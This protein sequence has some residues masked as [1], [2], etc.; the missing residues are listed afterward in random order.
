VLAAPAFGNAPERDRFC[1]GT[2]QGVSPEEVE[3]GE[4]V[5]VRAFRGTRKASVYREHVLVEAAFV[6]ILEVAD[7]EGL[8][9]LQ[10]LDQFGPHELGKA[11]ARRL[12]NEATSIRASGVLPELDDELTALAEVANWCA[13][14]TDN[15]WLRI[16]GP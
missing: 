2:I 11:D 8:T 5:E 12:A 10:S 14:A 15:S 16:E 7:R 9:L 1:L 4:V 13:R 3:V 6:R